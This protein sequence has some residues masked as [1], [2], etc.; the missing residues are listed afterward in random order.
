MTKAKKHS[1]YREQW[2]HASL[3]EVFAFFS[4]AANLDRI[5][6]PW[7]HFRILHAPEKIGAG[8]LIQYQLAWHG[9]PMRWTTRIE[10]WQPPHKFVDYQL[11]GP[12]RLWHHTHTFEERDG[13]TL[14]GDELQYAIPLGAMGDFFA[15]WRV[16]LDV[17]RI[18]D[19]RAEQIC[20]IFGSSAT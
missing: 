8:V 16:R 18:F 3:A 2:I 19:Y 10:E 4:D 15:G 20:A 6:P 5:T 11:R 13:R 14:M 1:L 17:E 12:Y 9:I 7:L